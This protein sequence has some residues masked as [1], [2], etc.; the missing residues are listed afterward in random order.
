VELR[1]EN[2]KLWLAFDHVQHVNGNC[3]R[4]I[5]NLTDVPGFTPQSRMTSFRAT[6]E[7]SPDVLHHR[8]EFLFPPAVS[9][10]E[11]QKVRDGLVDMVGRSIKVFADSDSLLFLAP[12]GDAGTFGARIGVKER[13]AP[14][15]E[16]TSV[17][18]LRTAGFRKT[19]E[20]TFVTNDLNT[21]RTDTKST[22]VPGETLD[23]LMEHPDGRKEPGVT[24]FITRRYAGRTEYF[25]GFNWQFPDS[26]SSM[27]IEAIG[28]VLRRQMGRPL[29][30]STAESFELFRV[31]NEFGGVFKGHLQYQRAVPKEGSP[32][33]ALVK[34]KQVHDLSFSAFFVDCAPTIPP[35]Y[36]LEVTASDFPGHRAP[37]SSIGRSSVLFNYQG[38]WELP[39]TFRP[40]ARSAAAQVRS[41]INAPPMK[42]VP[43]EPRLL[44]SVTNN[45]GEVY[46]GFLE[47]VGPPG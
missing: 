2:D 8:M 38:M 43:G 40:N 30:L 27:Q 35:G 42:V 26:I 9:R 6:S 41:L 44:F 13:T 33:E 37:T 14:R 17:R 5:H 19:I 23:C 15:Q 18:T 7:D 25:H 22:I 16:E 4:T 10:E 1:Q 24:T 31:T 45:V 29:V 21:V 47:L 3:E 36:A 46:K 32:A 12:V 20:L 34:I 28:A 11:A 39:E